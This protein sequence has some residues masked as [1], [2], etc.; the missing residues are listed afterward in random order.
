[1]RIQFQNGSIL[2]MIEMGEVID[3]EQIVCKRCQK[4]I[5]MFRPDSERRFCSTECE[6]RYK[7]E[8]S[9]N[10]APDQPDVP[11]GE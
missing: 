7:I 9:L 1:M 5:W 2:E 10:P 4:P 11:G 8:H 6:V 3:M